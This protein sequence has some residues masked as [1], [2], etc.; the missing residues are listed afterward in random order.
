MYQRIKLEVVKQ[1]LGCCKKGFKRCATP[2][3]LHRMDK[4]IQILKAVV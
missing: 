1:A 2:I 3:G 4:G